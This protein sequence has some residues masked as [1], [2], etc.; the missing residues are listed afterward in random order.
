MFKRFGNSYVENWA[1]TSSI[2]KLLTL[3]EGVEQKLALPVAFRQCFIDC[4][5]NCCCCCGLLCSLLVCTVRAPSRDMSSG[6]GTQD[7]A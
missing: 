5:C 6:D 2:G 4:Y 7:G 1:M 3:D